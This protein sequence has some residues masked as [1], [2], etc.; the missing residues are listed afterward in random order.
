VS[1]AGAAGDNRI[2]FSGR[3]RGHTLRRGSYEVT[4]RAVDA[5]GNA[6]T[7]RTARLRIVTARRPAA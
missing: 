7:P 6:A 2:A 5:A 4:V 3:L 1:H